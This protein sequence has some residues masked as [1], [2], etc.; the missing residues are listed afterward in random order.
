MVRYILP[1]VG[2]RVELDRCCPHC[3][4]RGGVV[5]TGVRRRG[6]RDPKV[7]H[8]LQQRL[9]CPRCGM[10]WTARASGVK[11]GHQRSDRSE[12][13]GVLGYLLGLSY[14]GVEMLL[15]ALGC[16]SGKSSVERDVAAAGKKA[17][18]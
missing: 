3:R 13:L 8:V 17:R 10:T 18:S 14:R 4:H 2:E 7:A 15:T 6:I 16:S 1:S 12:A 11:A 5:H 9:R